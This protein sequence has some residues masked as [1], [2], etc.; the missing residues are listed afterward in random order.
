MERLDIYDDLPQGMRQY[1]STNGWHFSMKL[2]ERACKSMKDRSGQKH[3]LMDKDTV[4]GH[5]RNA[6]VTLEHN[7]LYDA[8]FVMNMAY[9]DYYG[10]S[11]NDFNS[12]ALFVKDYLDD[13]DGTPTR[14]MD[15][16]I[17]RS[18]GAGKPIDWESVL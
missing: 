11:I 1:L 8:A 14:A 3:Q 4:E 10:S 12:L 13:P 15:E 16:F 6:G 18:I 7:E 9:A 5:L 2:F 17:G